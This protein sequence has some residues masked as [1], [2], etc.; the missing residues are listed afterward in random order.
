MNEN[1]I[2]KALLNGKKNERI[3]FAV[4]PA[5]KK[6]M[7][8]LAEEECTTVSAL[9]TEIAMKEILEYAPKL[10]LEKPGIE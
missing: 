6:A 10:N 8:E 5:F 4:T 9:L 7:G 2:K 3:I 1:E